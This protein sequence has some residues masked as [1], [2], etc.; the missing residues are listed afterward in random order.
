MEKL[1]VDGTGPDETGP[2]ETG[3]DAMAWDETAW[4]ESAT[5]LRRRFRFA[6]FSEAFAFMTRVALL[7]ESAGHH[8]DWS[9][10]W[11][12]VDIGL[13]THSAGSTVTD[14]DRALASRIDALLG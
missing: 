8:P 11:N 9:N 10:S 3:P 14:R 4:V 2:D 7:A 5:N 13:T 12:V 1:T 6:D